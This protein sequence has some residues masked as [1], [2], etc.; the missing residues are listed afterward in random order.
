MG[1]LSLTSLI[2]VAAAAAFAIAG[3]V[4]IVLG[5]R[6]Q[7]IVSALHRSGE[8]VNGVVTDTSYESAH[9][10]DGRPAAKS[11][12]IE[13]TTAEG[14]T[15]HAA[16]AYSD[17]ATPHRTGEQVTVLHDRARPELFVSPKNGE[18]M[19]IGATVLRLGLGAGFV[20]IGVVA[21][22]L[23]FIIALLTS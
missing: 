19:G 18:Q 13:F 23:F 14:R 2:P 21:G 16:P 11:E 6:R 10:A 12:L 22:Y 7:L 4:M 9:N 15:V 8:R 5:I 17:L 1:D 3:V 20:L